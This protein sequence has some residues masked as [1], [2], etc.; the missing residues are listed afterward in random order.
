[1]RKVVRPGDRIYVLNDRRAFLWYWPE[2]EGNLK[3]G[4][5]DPIGTSPGRFWIVWSFPNDT[6]KRQAD[7]VLKYARSFAAEQDEV[8]SN[9][10]GAVLMTSDSEASSSPPN[11]DAVFV[12]PVEP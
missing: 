9:G 8:Y 6:G 1:M 10:G 11:V 4:A 3:A 7:P 12:V 2:A 5:D